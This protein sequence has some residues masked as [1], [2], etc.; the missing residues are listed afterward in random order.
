MKYQPNTK[1][2]LKGFLA[3]LIV[4]LS[5][6]VIA[7]VANVKFDNKVYNAAAGGAVGFAA[8]VLMGDPEIRDLSLGFAGAEMAEDFTADMLN[9]AVDMIVP[10]GSS[11][12]YLAGNAQNYGFIPSNLAEYTNE[13]SMP[14]DYATYYR[15]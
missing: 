15:R 13:V 5:P 7:K 12:P 4:K 1:T 6:G 8:G 2:V 10:S 14:D 9:S 11:V 3:G